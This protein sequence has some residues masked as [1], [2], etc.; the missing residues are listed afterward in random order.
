ME[1]GHGSRICRHQ[2][3]S[4]APTALLPW[5]LRAAADW[6][7]ERV[8]R[9]LPRSRRGR[10][11]AAW[12]WERAR[13]HCLVPG[14][15]APLLPGAR[16]G[17]SPL[18]VAREGAP[19]LRGGQGGGAA[20]AWGRGEGAAAAWGRGE[21]VAVAWGLGEEVLALHLDDDGCS[22]GSG[23]LFL[24]LLL[25]KATFRYATLVHSVTYT[26]PVS[27]LKSHCWR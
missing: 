8:R 26:L 13:R 15:G 17:A 12:G 2:P 3:S 10:A 23:F 24:R 14:E 5:K 6:A 27:N 9:L 16:E 18:P 4:V 20:A 1:T 19:L 11:A 7:R 22:C 25:E 21:G